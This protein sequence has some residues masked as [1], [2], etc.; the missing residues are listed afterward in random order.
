MSACVI[1]EY[2]WDIHNGQRVQIIVCL[3]F[4]VICK[5]INVIIFTDF[6]FQFFCRVLLPHVFG[7]NKPDSAQLP[8]MSAMKHDLLWNTLKMFLNFPWITLGIPLKLSWRA[9]ETFLNC[10]WNTLATPLTFLLNTLKTS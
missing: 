2:R 7:E 9:L 8:V 6:F 5:N 3:N 4:S 10:P 1:V